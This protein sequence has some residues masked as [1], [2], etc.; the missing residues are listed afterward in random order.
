MSASAGVPPAIFLEGVTS[1]KQGNLFMVDIPYGR[2]LR[3]SISEKSFIVVA[4]WDG[5]PNGLALTEDGTLVAADYKLGIVSDS[6][7]NELNEKLSIDPKTGKVSPILT[8][9]NLERFK[10]PNDVIVASNGD[11]CE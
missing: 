7:Q 10:G 4:Q 6:A 8:R 5:E 1:D 3:Y 9:K 2:I 11:I